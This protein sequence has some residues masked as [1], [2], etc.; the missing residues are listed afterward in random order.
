MI[1]KIL[2]PKYF[3]F[4][5][6]LESWILKSPKTLELL[7]NVSYSFFIKIQKKSVRLT[8]L[9]TSLAHDKNVSLV[10]VFKE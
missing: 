5:F 7:Y 8:N 4:I 9:K 3:I 1:H 10:V 2:R 6:I